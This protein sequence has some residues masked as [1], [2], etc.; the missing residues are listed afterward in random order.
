LFWVCEFLQD[1]KFPKQASI[2]AFYVPAFLRYRAQRLVFN[3][4]KLDGIYWN[5]P[6]L[7][8]KLLLF[9][10]ICKKKRIFLRR[11]R[12][13]ERRKGKKAGIALFFAYVG[14]FL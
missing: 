4:H 14:F 7:C 12:K 9:F 5:Y 1:S 3:I 11:K 8:A 10:D 2:N 6:I 13:N